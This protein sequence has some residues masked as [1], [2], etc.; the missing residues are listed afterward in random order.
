MSLDIIISNDDI[1]LIELSKS[2]VVNDTATERDA[3][4]LFA[5]IDGAI[6][7]IEEKRKELTAP[8]NQEVKAYNAKAKTIAEPFETAKAYLT[9]KMSDYRTSQAV[10]LAEAQRKQAERQATNAMLSGDRET[11]LD[12]LAVVDEIA[13]EVPK[14]MKI[15][16]ATV[17][18]RTEIV[19]D[20]VDITKLDR[21]YIIETADIAKSRQ[22]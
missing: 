13:A 12:K 18:F 6:K 21:R 19:I 8:L 3:A 22:T 4:F 1:G 5:K 11:M 7:K 10:I 2:M 16:E 14:T 17:Q 9:Q 20:D 15:D